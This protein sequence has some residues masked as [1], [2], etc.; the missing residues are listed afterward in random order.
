[1]K[2]KEF[3]QLMVPLSERL[4]RYAYTLIPDD[5]QAEQ[6]V[7]DGFNAFLLR[8][9]K[10]ILIKDFKSEDKKD[11]TILRRSFLKAIL[12]NIC[13]IG[14]RRSVHLLEQVKKMSPDEYHPFFS[15]EPKVRFTIALRYEAQFSV[16]EI[17]E[18]IQLPRYEVI[19]KLHNGRFLLMN[20]LNKGTSP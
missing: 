12:R 13:D 3:Y 17:E 18:I 11:L 7:V 16:E 6:L 5:L 9:R 14:F 19:E 20:Q 10:K 1:M 2:R 15:L 8:E 4:Y